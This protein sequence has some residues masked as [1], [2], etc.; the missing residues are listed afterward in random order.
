MLYVMLISWLSFF[1]PSVK[2]YNDLFKTDPDP[3]AMSS[4][5]ARISTKSR[6]HQSLS[7]STPYDATP[8]IE[9]AK[10]KPPCKRARLIRSIKTELLDNEEEETPMH[11]EPNPT[12]PQW[13]Q[14]EEP[15]P[16]T[17]RTALIL[18]KKRPYVEQ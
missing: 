8:I 12:E 7:A 14:E 2:G 11:I 4:L 18:P 3:T 13:Q 10:K 15:V 16:S 5:P 6:V 9:A 17:S 1:R